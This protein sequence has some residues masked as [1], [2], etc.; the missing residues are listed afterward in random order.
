MEYDM[1]ATA[2]RVLQLHVVIMMTTPSSFVVAVDAG[3][4]MIGNWIHSQRCFLG[5]G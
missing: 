2:P 1:F 4:A 5:G 3:V